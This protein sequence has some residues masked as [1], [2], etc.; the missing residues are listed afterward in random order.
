MTPYYDNDGITIYCADMRAVEL[1]LAALV[2]TDPPYAEQTHAGARREARR[3]E[4]RWLQ[5][6]NQPQKLIDFQSFSLAEQR[7]CFERIATIA[8]RWVV[9]FMDWHHIYH[10]EQEP[11]PGL[12]FVRFGVWIKPN[13][14]PQFTGDRP[15]S[16]W[17]GIAFLHRAEQRMRWNGGGHHGVYTYPIVHSQH[18]LG[19]NPTAKPIPLVAE[20]IRQFSDP[21]DLIVDPFMGSGTTLAAAKLLGRRAIGIE[22]DE[23]QCTDL[24]RWLARPLTTARRRAVLNELPTLFDEVSL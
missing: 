18:K 13:G 21:G 7:Q 17:E 14:A 5:G 12:R 15:G 9:S 20:L 8:Q 3:D 1:P 24:V 11:P 4:G 10:F 6:G 22:R 2:L 23:A 16:G 19:D